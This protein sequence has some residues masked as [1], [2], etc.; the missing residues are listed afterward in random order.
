MLTRVG[1]PQ[2]PFDSAPAALVLVSDGPRQAVAGEPTWTDIVGWSPD[3]QR[4]LATR[5]DGTVVVNSTG[6]VVMSTRLQGVGSPMWR[7]DREIAIVTIRSSGQRELARVDAT[8]GALLKSVAL[9]STAMSGSF[10]RDGAYLAF[11]TGGQGAEPEVTIFDP[12]TDRSERLGAGTQV[13]GWTSAGLVYLRGGDALLRP[14]NGS[15]PTTILASVGQAVVRADHIVVTR[16]DGQVW[17]GNAGEA[18]RLIPNVRVMDATI[19]SLS[20]DGR[21]V[22][23]FGRTSSGVQTRIV[24]LTTGITLDPCDAECGRPRL[25]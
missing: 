1:S 20:S 21:F 13:V 22:A 8:T 12:A 23:T 9:P 16:A 17:V 3:G 10:S 15:T 5:A 11:Q 24:D 7:G 4:L 2:L 18:L 6:S 19:W 25:R 14:V